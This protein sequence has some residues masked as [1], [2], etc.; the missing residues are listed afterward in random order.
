MNCSKLIAAIGNIDDKFVSEYV[1]DAAKKGKTYHLLRRWGMIAAC[2]TLLVMAYFT[3]PRFFDTANNPKEYT[4]FY[5]AGYEEFAAVLPEESLLNDVAQLD[6]YE[7]ACMGVFEGKVNDEDIKTD[8]YLSFD[9]ILSTEEGVFAHIT[10]VVQ[11]SDSIDVYANKN[12]L[13]DQIQI[14]DVQLFYGYNSD[15][16][17]LLSAFEYSGNMY[18]LEVYSQNTDDLMNLVEQILN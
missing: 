3:L 17:Y 2:V 4:N 18:T 8:D 1:V 6:F 14:A 16:G 5:F 9:V 15:E 12:C 11:P 10:M 13:M 7:I